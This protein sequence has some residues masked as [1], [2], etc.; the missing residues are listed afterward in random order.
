MAKRVQCS[1]AILW[2]SCHAT[3][4]LWSQNCF[5]TLGWRR[6]GSFNGAGRGSWTN[7]FCDTEKLLFDGYSV[8]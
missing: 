8:F 6:T 4:R 7:G 3:R 2:S 5:P 1:Y